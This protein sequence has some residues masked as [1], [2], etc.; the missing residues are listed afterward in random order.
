MGLGF[1]RIN[2]VRQTSYIPGSQFQGVEPFDDGGTPKLRSLS[3]NNVIYAKLATAGMMAFT[4]EK[5]TDKSVVR[6]VFK[7]DDRFDLRHDLQVRVLWTHAN[8]AA[9]GDRSITWRI[10]HGFLAEEAALGGTLTELDFDADYP[11]V[12]AFPLLVSP[13]GVITA[14]GE[15]KK[16]F[17]FELFVKTYNAALTEAVYLVGLEIEYTENISRLKSLRRKRR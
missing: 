14:P 5:G 7:I 6:H 8:I 3:N 4:V 1:T 12:A 9:I 16:F 2:T 17:E 10:D 13:W 15:T 11:V